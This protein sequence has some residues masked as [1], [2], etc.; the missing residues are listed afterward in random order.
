M[1]KKLAKEQKFSQY[2][3]VKYFGMNCV[4]E[5]SIDSATFFNLIFEERSLTE[6]YWK[7]SDLKRSHY[8]DRRNYIY[9]VNCNLKYIFLNSANLFTNS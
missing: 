5:V 3:S 1:S 9:V 6:R 8:L 2:F 4:H 7:F